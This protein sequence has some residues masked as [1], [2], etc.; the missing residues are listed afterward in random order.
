MPSQTP[1]GQR[2][3]YTW[4]EEGGQWDQ[5]HHPHFG[6]AA[7]ETGLAAARE[8]NP[9]GGPPAAPERP[10]K[11]AKHKQDPQDVPPICSLQLGW[12]GS[13]CPCWEP[14]VLKELPLLLGRDRRPILGVSE[15]P[16]CPPWQRAHLIQRASQVRAARCHHEEKAMGLGGGCHPTPPLCQLLPHSGELT[17]QQLYGVGAQPVSGQR[18]AL[19][20]SL[21]LVSGG[22]PP[23]R[24]QGRGPAP[25]LHSASPGRRY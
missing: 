14:P 7:L 6:S 9:C 10:P 4:A 18:W 16:Q 12:G 20:P 3:L 11:L 25:P 17:Q 13:V 15:S 19:E 5:P 22:P 2:G 21:A 8:P 23:W 1:G 24:W